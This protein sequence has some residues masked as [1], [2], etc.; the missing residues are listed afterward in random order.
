MNDEGN[1]Q[2]GDGEP[3]RPGPAPWS[4][5][6]PAFAPPP[7]FASPSTFSAGGP[8]EAAPSPAV[9]PVPPTRPERR[10]PLAGAD[11]VDAPRPAP[12]LT[13][14]LAVGGGLLVAFGLFFVLAELDGFDQRGVAL[15]ISV[16]FMALGVAISTINRSNRSAAAGVVISALAVLPLTIY[17]YANADVFG[18]LSGGEVDGNPWDGVRGII[19]LILATAAVLWLL[20]YFLGPARRFGF[21]LGAALVAIWL[22]PIATI[23]ITAL[24]D[25]LGSFETSSTFEP[26][27]IDPDIDSGFDS[28]FDSEFDSEFDSDF[29]SQ[30]DEDFESQFDEDVVFEEP[31]VSDPSTRLGVI[32]LVFGAAYLGFAARRD[33]RGDARMAT[34]V[35]VPALLILVYSLSLL[36]THIGWVGIGVLAMAVGGAILAVGLAGARRASSWIGLAVATIGLASLLVNAFEES[37]RAIGAALTVTGVVIALLV[38]RFDRTAAAS[39]P[40]SPSADPLGPFGPGAGGSG[41]GTPSPAT[42]TPDAAPASAPTFTAPVPPPAPP[43]AE[44]PP[45][46]QQF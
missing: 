37:P 33:R 9:P 43:T 41:A 14:M 3:G 18:E 8:P 7:A 26:V 29:D 28:G 10:N 17:L 44:P 11:P 45:W 40:P 30:F 34:A 42:P 5:E 27:P 39:S 21:Y 4:G 6:P 31:E 46:S 24:E 22:I 13:S 23:Q 1:D 25:T 15:A 12:T 20:G 35:L 36:T 2:A 16:L 32:S 19:T 38:G